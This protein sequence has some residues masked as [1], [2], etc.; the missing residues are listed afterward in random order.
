MPGPAGR[1]SPPRIADTPAVK[2]ET[3]E[4]WVWVLLYGGLLILSFGIFVRRASSALGVAMMAAGGLAA[5]MG[6][7][8]IYIRSRWKDD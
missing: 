6:I 3:I 1:P 2:R 5:L 7:A 4:T 8:L